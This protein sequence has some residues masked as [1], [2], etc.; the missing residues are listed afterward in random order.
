M[1][2]QGIS[3]IL[4]AGGASRRMGR[5][6]PLLKLG[7][8]TVLERTVLMLHTA[9]ITD[10]RVVT[11]YAAEQ[12]RARHPNLP[13]TW[14]HN[15][16]P[17]DGMFASIQKGTADLPTQ[18]EG[19]LLLPAD[20]P[21]V[22]PSTIAA[23]LSAWS[24]ANG[25]AAVLYPTFRARRGH[26]PLI[27]T[28]LRDRILAPPQ[29]GGLRALLERHAASA[30][31]VPVFDR[32]ILEDM[33]TPS[34]YEHLERHLAAYDLPTAEECEALLKDP[35]MFTETTAAH[36][37]RVAQVAEMLAA[38]VADGIPGFNPAR[39]RAGALL[40]DIAKGQPRHARAGAAL[41]AGFGFSGLHDIVSRHMDLTDESGTPALSEAALVYLADKL[42]QNDQLVLLHKRFEEKLARYGH[43]PG[44][45]DAV[46]RRKEHALGVARQIEAAAGCSLEQLLRAVSGQ[47]S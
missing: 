32:F 8:H 11:G 37:R 39:L 24:A 38:P 6:K 18:C 36:C 4:P 46:R 40:H 22:R 1:T 27:S 3:A 20:I 30:R 28:R 34:A 35:R 12:I 13:V 26:P 21:L 2:Q 42:V 45:R 5:S 31:E 10:I 14:V 47:T 9:G 41:L 16:A 25:D 43:D 44:A 29:P 19:F 23:L 15:P 33:D 17:E 7:P